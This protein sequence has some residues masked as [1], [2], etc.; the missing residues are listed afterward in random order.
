MSPAVA[1]RSPP[2]VGFVMEQTLGSVT[3]SRNLRS[4]IVAAGGLEPIWQELPYAPGALPWALRGSL[5]ARRLVARATAAGAD[6]IV[7]HTTTVSLLLA[8]FARRVP[9]IVSTDATAA[10]KDGMRVD[11]GLP[12]R[13]GI[14]EALKLAAY[15]RVF[16][17]AAG[18]IVWCNW[19]AA[20]LA[21]DY[22]VDPDRI[23]VIPPGTDLDG[24]RPN[25]RPDT[26]GGPARL[27]KLLFVGGDFE[28]KGGSLLLDVFRRRFRH[29]AELHLVTGAEMPA[30]PG[31]FLHRGLGPNDPKL[32]EL[33]R[34][35]DAFVF[36]TRS[37]CF[38]VA[39]IEA[40]AAGLPVVA[41]R[42]GGLPDQVLPGRT[43]FLVPPDDGLSLA[44]A[45]ERIVSDGRLRLRMGVA[46][47]ARALELYDR[48]RNAR[49]TVDVIR[50]TITC[51]R[52][53]LRPE[54]GFA[55]A[56]GVAR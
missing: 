50:R 28:R 4:G 37:D 53:D 15:S 24:L 45:I 19:A 34:G 41:T 2:R 54:S 21:R 16:S 51:W 33:F 1:E 32:L 49:R 9:L 23:T 29:R 42:V 55:V 36:P 38:P 52:H 6:A 30:E 43:G 14:A 7:V 46:A 17:R 25:Q 27:A 8:G 12:R 11:Y 26:P 56:P 39:T 48:G 18:F 31:V 13:G 40:M 20:S 35:A 5:A 22:G 44:A 3:Y 10:N 47:R